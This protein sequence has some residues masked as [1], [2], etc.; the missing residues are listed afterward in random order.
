MLSFYNISV[1]KNHHKFLDFLASLF[2]IQWIKYIRTTTKKITM[3]NRESQDF[4]KTLLSRNWK[5]LHFNILNNFSLQRIK[6]KFT[7]EDPLLSSREKCQ[8][9]IFSV[10]II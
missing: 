7:F 3:V 9:Y 2:V 6:H 1:K 8:L 10:I 5:Y 4:R